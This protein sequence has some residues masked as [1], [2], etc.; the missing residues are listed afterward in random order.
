[1]VTRKLFALCSFVLVCTLAA[2]ALGQNSTSGAIQGVVRDKATDEGLAGVTVVV[3]SPALQGTQSAITDGTGQYKITNLPPGTYSA[4]YYYSDITVRQNNITVNINK[5]TPGHVKM[6]TSQAGGE[7]I[8][9]DSKAPSIDPTS[10]TQGV[11]LDQDY[12]RNIP[13]PGRTFEDAL[14]AA[15]GSAGDALGVSFSGSTSL[16]NSYVVDG[17]NTTGL[18]YGTVGSALINDFIEEIEIITGGYNAEYGRATGGVVNVV[19]K[20]GSNDFAGSV[21]TYVTPGFLRADADRAASEASSIDAE[22]NLAYAMD[23][24]FD[25]GGPIIK[26]KVWFYVGFA[27]ALARAD[28]D[29][30]TK[31]RTDCRETMP[32]GTLSACDPEQFGD[33]SPDEDPETGFLI[34]EE[35]DR[36]RRE[37]TQ[38]SYQFVS[39]VNFALSPE[40]QGQVSLI[41]TPA[42][43]ETVGVRG[44]PSATS[45]DYTQLTTDLS[46]K[47]TSKL[48]NNKT[49]VE[50]VLGWHRSTFEADSIVNSENDNVRQNLYFGNLGTWSMLGY[51]SETTRRGCTD[52]GDRTVDP[53]PFIPNCPDEG[54]GYRIGGPGGIADEKEER[55]SARLSATQRV[56]AAGNHEIKAGI[57]IES[58]H[59]NKVRNISGGV[60][61]D[62]YQGGFNRVQALRWVKLGPRET[63]DDP[64]FPDTCRNRG[65]DGTDEF[66]CEFLG[67]TDVLGNTQNWSLYARDSWQPLPN[68]TLNYGLRYEEQR[69]RYAEAL[70]DTDDPFTGVYRGKNAMVIQNMWAPRLGAL[71][72]WTKEGRSKV[73]GHW[74]RFYESIPMQINDRSFGGET[75]YLQDYDSATQCG[76]AVD[77]IGG[78]SGPGCTNA[79][80]VAANGETI[81]G[82]GV[83]IA[84]DIKGQFLDE[85]I[86][87]I[88]YEVLEDLKVGLAYKDRRLGR[89][90]E[91]VSVDNADTYILAN[92]GEV[93][94]GAIDD[95]E[96]DLM[97]LRGCEPSCTPE[98]Q[99][100]I[101][102][103]ANQIDQF[104]KIRIFDKPRRDYK[105]IEL[106]ATKRFSQRFF[107]QGSYTYSRTQ[108][109]YPGLFSAD[110]GQVDP[111]ISSQFDLIELLSNRD[112]PLP[113]DRPHYIKVDGYYVFDFKKAGSLTTGVR[114]RAL[115]GTPNNA[116]GRHYLY[117]INEAFLLPRGSMPR[118]P[119]DQGVDIKLMYGRDLGKGMK[120][121][122]F[123]DLFSLFN[124]QGTAGRSDIYT[125]DPVN[126]IVGGDFEDLV[127]AKAQS[128]S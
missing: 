114:F 41:G 67:P 2:P 122:V 120:V 124:T 1:M 126:P 98:Q 87:G 99:T 28:I 14:G 69:L 52:S 5:A 39:K 107:M 24:G 33:G 58:N 59:L 56:K 117:G 64:E 113:Q 94:Q 119:F 118:S 21:F 49:E 70:Q 18:N 89:I 43:G 47:W 9:L 36:E 66:A 35:I 111:N 123:T 103:L 65:L 125:L 112:G 55:L 7:V 25:L 108:G 40:H 16:E 102:Q 68:I 42:S 101:N 81:F 3:T 121:E 15:A 38:S 23:F 90:L 97:G 86:L 106:T 96:R 110:N 27:P 20:S 19:T 116:L 32:D 48:N 51:E 115:S 57:D 61:Y 10:T 8:V 72:D 84:P 45:F 54:E 74:G 78:P 29:K 92:P 13:I 76:P 26:D 6:N 31:R 79:G 73:Y 37:A 80:Q 12:T 63:M 88:E 46:A 77:G 11:T 17:V 128:R 109:N 100:E 53:Y 83:L 34:Y 91:D 85:L 22:S 93:P 4:T 104:K 127:F 82:S 50:A 30:V 44:A 75:L 105:A 62:V 71:Y 60:Y 95:L